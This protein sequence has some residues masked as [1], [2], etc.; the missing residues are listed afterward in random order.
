MKNKRKK[1]LIPLLWFSLILHT[2]LLLI[3]LIF[4][5]KKK[6][7]IIIKKVSQEKKG[8]PA[9][10]HPKKSTFGTTILF[11]DKAVFSPAKA[12][13]LSKLE[14]KGSK[15]KQ[16]PKVKTKIK[17][18]KKEKIKQS[19][20]K[21]EKLKLVKKEKVPKIIEMKKKKKDKDI[22]KRI[23]QIEKK[24]ALIAKAKKQPRIAKLKTI[25]KAQE[26]KSPIQPPKKRSIIAMTKGFIENLKNKGDD[27]LERKGDPNK[28]PD[29]K[30]LKYISYEQKI[31]WYLQNSWKQHFA[32]QPWQKA[33]EGKAIIDFKINEDGSLKNVYM[34]QSSGNNNLD[35]MIVK[36]VEYAAPFPPLPKHFGK[37]TYKTGRIIYV[38][39][40]KLS[41]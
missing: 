11:D 13:L 21:K 37:K 16:Q 18:R 34:L 27:W 7:I 19:I 40:H 1:T 33:L 2:I 25:G 38:Y 36:S 41:I 29:F 14:Q 26:D 35:D 3:L 6:I 4:A 30:E 22:E 39:S 9:A 32:H 10:L 8:L 5:F 17:K 12:K 28:R 15:P 31:N 20:V 23:K 24:Q